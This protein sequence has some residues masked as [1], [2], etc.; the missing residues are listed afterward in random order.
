MSC[1]TISFLSIGYYDY[2]ITL[3]TKSCI[4]QR[5]KSNFIS[6]HPVIIFIADDQQ[7]ASKSCET[8]KSNCFS[9]KFKL[10]FRQGANVL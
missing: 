5:D 1:L 10:K 7:L 6:F 9:L 8:F 3:D 4:F 2:D